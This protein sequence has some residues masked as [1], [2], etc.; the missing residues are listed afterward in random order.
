MPLDPEQRRLLRK[1]CE[2]IVPGFR[3]PDV[4]MEF[5][6]VADWCE[7]QG[8][9][10]DVY[11]EGALVED[12][13]RKIASLLGKEAAL[14]VPSGVMAQLIAVRLW[15]ERARNDRFGVHPTS[16]LLLHE[17]EAFAAVLQTHAVVLGDRLRPMTAADLDASRQPMACV[18]V[19]LPIREAG[20]LLP[21]WEELEALKTVARRRGIALHMDGAR[22]WESAAFYRR[23]HAEIAAG[24]DSVYVSVYKGIGALAG[25]LLAGDDDFIANARLWRRRIGGTLYRMSPMV[26][27][28]AMR[29]DER[30]ALM[31]ALYERTL[32]LTA[33]LAD[34]PT[35]RVPAVPH[36]NLL[37]LHFGA[38][39]ER[40]LAARD[41]V[42]ESTG[43]W[44]FDRV[45]ATDVPD[46]SVTEL[47]VGDRLLAIDDERLAACFALLGRSMTSA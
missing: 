6:L 7:A 17:S 16:H 8:V 5:R 24:F 37:H 28:A 20:G 47:Y 25:A 44:L 26:A 3:L 45:A 38:A 1:R 19:E 12:F 32:R 18:L 42:A 29:F 31:P 2:T 9:E 35:L 39:V 14:F 40:V 4:A 46:W 36:T 10:H 22:L 11:G 23:S 43:C 13:E 30:I 41:A 21:D 34:E 27:S 15:T 33:T